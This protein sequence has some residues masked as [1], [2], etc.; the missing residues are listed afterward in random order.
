MKHVLS[1]L[2]SAL[3]LSVLSFA[4]T[5]EKKAPV[6]E[7]G[8]GWGEVVIG[9][10]REKIDALLGEHTAPEEHLG[11]TLVGYT[12]KGIHVSFDEDDEADAIYFYNKA[13]EHENYATFQG[14]TDKGID[15]SA[16]PEQIIRAYGKPDTEV[17]S[18]KNDAEQ[19]RRFVYEGIDFYF[20]DGK[21]VRIGV[22]GN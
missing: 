1:L 20:E 12:A 10:K 11:T 3:A 16:T 19:W 4:Q 17:G 9:A 7:A 18:E 14:K 5:I 21:L 2:L 22:P 15:W 13:R 6:I 8:K